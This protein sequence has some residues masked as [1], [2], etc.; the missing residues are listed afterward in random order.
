MRLL[1]DKGAKA[2][3]KNNSGDSPLLLAA[4]S[5]VEV[6]NQLLRA[7]AE[8]DDVAIEHAA[9]NVRSLLRDAKAAQD[10]RQLGRTPS[11]IVLHSAPANPSVTRT[12]NGKGCCSMM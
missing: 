7:R 6:V 3:T 8:V 4:N 12:N 1:L 9:S 2:N 5:H 10:R 11:T